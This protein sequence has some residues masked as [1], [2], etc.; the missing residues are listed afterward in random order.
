MDQG[1]PGTCFFILLMV[2][3]AV[4]KLFSVVHLFIFA[5][6]VFAFGV[7]SKKSF[8]A[9]IKGLPTFVFF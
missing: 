4:Q 6:V 8:E 9:N 3:F 5:F 1:T 7:K 2:S